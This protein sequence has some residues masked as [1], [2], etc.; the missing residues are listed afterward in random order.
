MSRITDA[1]NEV[2]LGNRILANEGVL[3]AYGHVS[4]RHPEDPTRFLL[5]CSRSPEHVE[6]PDIMQFMLDGQV[7]DGRRDQPYLERFI[8]GAIY[9][10]DPSIQAVVHSHALDVLAFS[11]SQV[12]LRPVIHTASHIGADIPV[13]DIADR[14]GDT[15]LLVTNIEQGRDLAK[16][17]SAGRV[18]LMRG[19]GF[20][21]AGRTLGEVLK[22]SIYLPQNARVLKEAM[23]LGGGVKPLSSKE[24]EIR[25]AAGPGGRELERAIEY[26]ARKAGAGEFLVRR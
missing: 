4:L 17:L 15:S 12:P 19:H 18:A 2:V 5:S 13:W 26:W 7:A 3:D 16:T 9:E 6:P 1:V 14:F 24:I 20:A 8:H 10:A 11:I 25:D 21:A 23:Q 22:V